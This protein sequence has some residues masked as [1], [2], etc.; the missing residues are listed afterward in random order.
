LTTLKS[1]D[2]DKDGEIIGGGMSLM[3]KAGVS[4]YFRYDGEI[5]SDYTSQ[6]LSGGFR[7]EF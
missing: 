7:Y 5:R 6:Q 1:I 3:N 2:V 4:I